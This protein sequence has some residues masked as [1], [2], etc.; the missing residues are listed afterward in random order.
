MKSLLFAIISLC[1]L[2]AVNVG[3]EVSKPRP[4]PHIDQPSVVIVRG[5]CVLK[6]RGSTGTA[7]VDREKCDGCALC[8]Q[9]CPVNNVA[10][11]GARPRWLVRCEQCLACMQWCPQ[12]AIQFSE[13]T[14][15]WGRYHHPEIHVDELIRRTYK[16]K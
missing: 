5:A 7:V 11:E 1:L 16:E 10:I 6:T 13:R 3:Y 12:K 4:V 15:T 2:V 8:E 14:S 9:V